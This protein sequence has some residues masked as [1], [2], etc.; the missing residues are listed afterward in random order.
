MSRSW[1]KQ[2]GYSGLWDRLSYVVQIQSKHESAK[3]YTYENK[4][5]N[6]AVVVLE[7]NGRKQLEEATQLVSETGHFSL[8]VHSGFLVSCHNLERGLTQDVFSPSVI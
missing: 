2:G 6:I 4:E 8:A 3:R 5:E 1:T 7:G